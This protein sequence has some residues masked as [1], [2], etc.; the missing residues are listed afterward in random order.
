MFWVK[1]VMRSNEKL[2]IVD[3]SDKSEEWHDLRTVKQLIS[4]GT[5]QIFGV[6]YL[7]NKWSIRATEDPRTFLLGELRVLARKKRY[8]GFDVD[9]DVPD[10]LAVRHFGNWEISQEDK[11]QMLEEYGE[12]EEDWDWKELTD[13]TDKAIRV[14]LD[15]IERQYG[16]TFIYEVGEKNWLYFY[17]QPRRRR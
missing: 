4:T 11:Q 17:N 10:Y 5:V 9:M 7:G 6:A 15:E 16:F 13:D 3:T 8:F 1:S 12:I 14:L 2:L